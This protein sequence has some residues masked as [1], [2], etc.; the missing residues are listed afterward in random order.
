MILVVCLNYFK[1]KEMEKGKGRGM[2]GQASRLS[3]ESSEVQKKYEEI[4]WA[5]TECYSVCLIG[6]L[7]LNLGYIAD[8]YI[9]VRNKR[10]LHHKDE[11]KRRKTNI[12]P[13]LRDQS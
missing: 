4:Q 5:Y 10:K 12:A 7:W 8:E 9:V 13:F 1:V 2:T 6:Y 11:N 3:Y